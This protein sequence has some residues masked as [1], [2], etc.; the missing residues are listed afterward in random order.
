MTLHHGNRLAMLAL[1]DALLAACGATIDD[2]EG[3]VNLPLAAREVRSSG[4]D[5]APGRRHAPRQPALEGRRRRPRDVATAGAAAA[6]QRRRLHDDGSD[7]KRF[8]RSWSMRS[9]NIGSSPAAVGHGPAPEVLDGV[10]LI[11]KPSGPTSHD[12]VARMRRS[13]GERSIGHTGTL[14]PRATGLLPLV[15]GRATRLASLL[16][17]GDKT[18]DATDPPGLRHRHRRRGGTPIGQQTASLPDDAA[19]ATALGALRR[20][21]G[22]ASARVLGQEDRRAQGVRVRA[23]SGARRA[24]ARSRSPSTALTMTAAPAIWS[25]WKCTASAGSTSGRWRATSASGSAAAPT[26]PACGGPRRALVGVSE[27]CRSPRRKRLGRDVA[28]RLI[29]RPTPSL[30]CR[31]PLTPPGLR[32]VAHGNPVGPEHLVGGLPVASPPSPVR[33]GR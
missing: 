33:C 27:P 11:D 17:G 15:L 21:A 9:A 26:S 25:R 5:Q 20:L 19:L 12:V 1:D 28:R 22:P 16:T 2:T 7:S 6:T 13:S 23:G 8:V 18:Y 32:R 4:A 24:G 10:L 31:R 30:T 3:L 29:S 14:D